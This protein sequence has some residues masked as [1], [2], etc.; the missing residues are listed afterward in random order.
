MVSLRVAVLA[1]VILTAVIRF[2]TQLGKQLISGTAPGQELLTASLLVALDKKEEI[3]GVRPIVMGE[4]IYRYLGK[5]IL[6]IKQ[7][8]LSAPAIPTG[9]G[10][11]RRNGTSNATNARNLLRRPEQQ[12]QVYHQAGLQK[13]VR[14]GRQKENG[15][16]SSQPRA[17]PL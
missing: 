13:R 10:I 16:R 4:L 9:S 12:V 15:V 7:K 3:G 17:R 14:L 2:L 1:S 5:A 11:T 8:Q 6:K